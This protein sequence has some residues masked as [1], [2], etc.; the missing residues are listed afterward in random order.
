MSA[1]LACDLCGH[2][3]HLPKPCHNAPNGG[4]CDCTA[5]LTVIRISDGVYEVTE[6]RE[7]HLHVADRLRHFGYRPTRGNRARMISS[8]RRAVQEQRPGW[9][10]VVIE[11]EESE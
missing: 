10:L 1:H 5:R 6:K 7:I 8:Y 3:R 9:K 4:T 2:P 11:E